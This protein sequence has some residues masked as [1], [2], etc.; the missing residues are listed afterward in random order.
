MTGVFVGISLRLY[1]TGRLFDA[2]SSSGG[3]VEESKELD[4]EAG[5]DGKQA[6]EAGDELTQRCC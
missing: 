1:T 6:E 5:C 2:L 3:T 4:T